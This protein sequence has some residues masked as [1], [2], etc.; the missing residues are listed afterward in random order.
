MLTKSRLLATVSAAALLLGAFIFGEFTPRANA[1]EALLPSPAGTLLPAEHPT[2]PNL[3]QR[4]DL[5]LG[6]GLSERP[7]NN[8]A[9]WRKQWAFSL[10]PLLVSESLDAASSYGMRELNPVLASSDGSFGM[11]SASLKFGAV[12]ALAGVE[13]A[14][15]KK[16]PRS[17]RFF[18]IVNW[19]TAGATTGLAVHNFRLP[20]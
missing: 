20:R 5:S 1:A 9:K 13:Y 18:T 14:L 17:A 16:Y 10:A 8:E 19:T 15:V 6:A 4:S 7:W 12:G 3:S 11:K 2:I